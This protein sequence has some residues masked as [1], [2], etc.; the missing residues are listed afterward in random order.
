MT[1]EV[2]MAIIHHMSTYSVLHTLSACSTY[3]GIMQQLDT[4]T[5]HCTV[6]VGMASLLW[7]TGQGKFGF[8]CI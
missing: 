7:V 2:N 3:M 6:V 5:L 8:T 1:G 4:S